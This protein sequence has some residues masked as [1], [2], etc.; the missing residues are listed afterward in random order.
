MQGGVGALA[1]SESAVHVSWQVV[2]PGAG[3]KEPL[4]NFTIPGDT[5]PWGE[6]RDAVLNPS[7][8]TAAMLPSPP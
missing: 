8:P 7:S 6:K 5:G 1:P 2:H 4:S 3:L